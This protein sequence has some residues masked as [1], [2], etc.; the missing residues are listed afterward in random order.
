[1]KKL[2]VIALI[3]LSLLQFGSVFAQTSEELITN[4]SFYTGTLY[5]CDAARNK[6]V[7]KNVKPMG[8]TNSQNRLT[9][10]EAEY[11]EIGVS[12]AAYLQDGSAIPLEECNRYADSYVRILITQSDADG[13]RVVNIKFL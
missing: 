10:L 3:I 13:L 1:M 12:G 8:K 6:I 11:N 5:Y 9:A 2:M 4:A 7:L